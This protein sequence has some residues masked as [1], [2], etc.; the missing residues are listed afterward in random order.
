M[1]RLIK[2]SSIHVPGSLTV[3]LRRSLTVGTPAFASCTAGTVSRAAA[4]IAD[5]IARGGRMRASV[6]TSGAFAGK[7]ILQHI[8]TVATAEIYKNDKR[9][10]YDCISKYR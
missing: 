7:F 2:M 6:R 4:D 10:Y 1:P 8:N 3:P 9:Q 5:G